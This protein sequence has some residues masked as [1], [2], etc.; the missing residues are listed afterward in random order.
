MCSWTAVQLS[1]LWEQYASAAR[2]LC[3][4]RNASAGREVFSLGEGSWRTI[5]ERV[6][7]VKMGRKK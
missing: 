2:L 7:R 3:V 5:G 6:R 4:R 1:A